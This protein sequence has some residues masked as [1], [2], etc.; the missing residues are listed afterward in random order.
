MKNHCFVRRQRE[1]CAVAV[2]SVHTL[3]GCIWLEIDFIQTMFERGMSRFHKQ[4]VAATS[5]GFSCFVQTEKGRHALR[6]KDKGLLQS[7]RH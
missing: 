6:L 1:L 5:G 2:S 7:Y 3:H 4:H